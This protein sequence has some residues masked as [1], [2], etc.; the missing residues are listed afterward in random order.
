[1]KVCFEE[2]KIIVVEMVIQLFDPHIYIYVHVY[3]YTYIY[4][5]IIMIIII[6]DNIYIYNIIYHISTCS[7]KMQI[8][9]CTVWNG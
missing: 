3:I 4:I 5:I 7:R 6:I 9:I 8:L 1:M 2:S